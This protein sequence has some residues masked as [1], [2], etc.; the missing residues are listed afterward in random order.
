MG[1]AAIPA[2]PWPHFPPVPPGFWGY[3][4]GSFPVFFPDLLCRLLGRSRR[5]GAGWRLHGNSCYSFSRR[6]LT[7]AG[8]RNAC[9]DLG[10]HLVV[11]GSDT[12]Q[13]FLLEHSERGASYWLGLTKGEEGMWSWVTGENSDF[14]YWDIWRKDPHRQLKN[15]STIGGEGR[16]VHEHCWERQRWICEKPGNC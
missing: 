11:V 10:A 3:F 7:W 2:L 12:E 4:L 9:S 5:C 15:C 16:W 1:T 6:S 13:E 14:R 8:A